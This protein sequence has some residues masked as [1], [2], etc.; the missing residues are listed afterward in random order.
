MFQYIVTYY[1]K[2][3][4]VFIDYTTHFSEVPPSGEFRGDVFRFKLKDA[5]WFI[6][7]NMQAIIYIQPEKSVYQNKL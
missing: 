7:K 3:K 5:T 6:N 1:D 2:F 4:I